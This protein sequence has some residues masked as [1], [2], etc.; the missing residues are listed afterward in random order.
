MIKMVNE[1]K[2]TVVHFARPNPMQI[3]ACAWIYRLTK[4]CGKLGLGYRASGPLGRRGPWA[5]GHRPRAAGRWAFGPPGRWAMAGRGPSF[6]KTRSER[7]KTSGNQG[8]NHPN[9][10]FFDGT[11]IPEDKIIR[12]TCNQDKYVRFEARTSEYFERKHN[13]GSNC[14]IPRHSKLYPLKS[15]Y[16]T[17]QFVHANSFFM[18]L[19]REIDTL[20][21]YRATGQRGYGATGLR[22]YGAMGLWGYGA[23]GLR[24]HVT[25]WLQGYVATRLRGYGAYVA[26]WLRGDVA[27]GLRS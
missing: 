9:H 10:R 1:F 20:Q 5:A 8:K 12:W 6:S 26:T 24:G 13:P 27:T 18:F 15:G 11:F 7:D 19:E 4:N 3:C 22:N 2:L 21:G 14:R 25:T 23:T 17:T 16:L